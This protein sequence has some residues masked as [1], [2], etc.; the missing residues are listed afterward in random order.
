MYI[1]KAVDYRDSIRRLLEE[2]V[3]KNKQPFDEAL[4]HGPAIWQPD[5]YDVEYLVNEGLSYNSSYKTDS[6]TY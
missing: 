5:S 1:K 3:V 4:N 6:F 2:A